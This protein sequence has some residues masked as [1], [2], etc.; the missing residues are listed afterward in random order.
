MKEIYE[1]GYE[2]GK[3]L[4]GKR[5]AVIQLIDLITNPKRDYNAMKIKVLEV[6]MKVDKTVPLFFAYLGVEDKDFSK[7]LN[8]LAMGINNGS[9]EE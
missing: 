9:L 3:E 4:K 5:T 7:E 1:Q 2:I 8:M 6:A